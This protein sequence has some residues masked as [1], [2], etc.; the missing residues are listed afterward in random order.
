MSDVSFSAA[1]KDQAHPTPIGHQYSYM[2]A[3]NQSVVSGGRDWRS[4]H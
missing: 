4:Q 2:V 1:S 3:P